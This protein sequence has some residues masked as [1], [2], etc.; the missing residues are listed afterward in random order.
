MRGGGERDVCVGRKPGVLSRGAQGSKLEEAKV[1][2]SCAHSLRRPERNYY[3]GAV[4]GAGQ[5]AGRKAWPG[6]VGTAHGKG[7]NMTKVMLAL[8]NLPLAPF[9]GP[10]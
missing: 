3:D 7:Q 8:I 9:A 10:C 4:S 1:A 6:L 2:D 5:R